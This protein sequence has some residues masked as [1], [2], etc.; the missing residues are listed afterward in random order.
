MDRPLHIILAGKHDVC[1]SDYDES[2]TL[3]PGPHYL[4]CRCG[5]R[6]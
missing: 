3:T 4:S 6:Q 1:Q 5:V 2:I